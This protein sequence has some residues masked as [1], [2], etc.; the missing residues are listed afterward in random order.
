MRQRH[1]RGRQE[2][3]KGR[4]EAGK[5]LTPTSV[6]A[7]YRIMWFRVNRHHRN[8]SVNLIRSAGC[9]SSNSSFPAFPGSSYGALHEPSNFFFFLLKNAQLFHSSQYST[10][11]A[12]HP[13]LLAICVNC[14]RKI[15]FEPLLDFLKSNFFSP[16]CPLILAKS[17]STV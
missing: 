5:G 3:E 15:I 4:V 7:A 12:F 10:F 9:F 2:D 6:C 13:S 16:V 1:N 11:Y 17:H 8:V 14:R